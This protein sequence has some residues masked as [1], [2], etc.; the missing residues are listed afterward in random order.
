MAATDPVLYSTNYILGGALLG[1]VV[2]L[3]LTRTDRKPHDVLFTGGWT[4][5]S[6]AM[7]AFIGRGLSATPNPNYI[8]TGLPP[9]PAPT[10]SQA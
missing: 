7:G 10:P 1:G 9:V 4:A 8:T 5:A 6:A 3:L 2:G